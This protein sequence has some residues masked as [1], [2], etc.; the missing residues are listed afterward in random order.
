MNRILLVRHGQT[1]WN[2]E[3]IFRGRADIEL[4][5]TGIR[6]AEL[7]ANYLKDRE[8]GTVYS[9]PLRRARRTAEIVAAPHRVEVR[10]LPGLIDLDFGK[11]QGLSV[12][13]VAH[14]YPELYATWLQHPEQVIMPGGEGLEDVRA[15]AIEVVNR[16]IGDT[17]TA[18]LVSHRVVIKVLICALLGLDNSRFWNI[19]I[20]TCGMTTFA[21]SDSRFVLVEHNN[22][23][24][25]NPLYPA[26]RPDF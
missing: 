2:I 25:L 6:Q 21:Y 3:E 11:W 7:L 8:I 16:T 15:R 24:F 17:G 22:T 26:P 18:V 10:P 20:D 4:D 9:S 14:K 13:E 5:G 12:K 23:A 1:L 19:R